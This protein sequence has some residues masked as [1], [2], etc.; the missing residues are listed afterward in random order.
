MGIHGQISP[1]L[2][3]LPIPISCDFALSVAVSLP[4][5]L[6]FFS[7]ASIEYIP[8]EKKGHDAAAA[9]S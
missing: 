3:L 1:T 4:L 7:I 6:L 2:H 5:K 8:G 9:I